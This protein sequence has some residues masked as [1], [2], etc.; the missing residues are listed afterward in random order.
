MGRTKK[1][2][3]FLSFSLIAI[4]IAGIIRSHLQISVN[5][6]GNESLRQFLWS[7]KLK[8]PKE[9]E[10]ITVKKDKPVLRHPHGSKS[11]GRNINI[12]LQSCSDIYMSEMAS[13]IDT[14][15]DHDDINF[16]FQEP[17]PMFD[18]SLVCGRKFPV[19]ALRRMPS[20]RAAMCGLQKKDNS[21]ELEVRLPRVESRRGQRKMGGLS[22]LWGPKNTLG[23][24]SQI[25]KLSNEMREKYGV[26]VTMPC[27]ALP[28]DLEKMKKELPILKQVAYWIFKPG[29][30]VGGSGIRFLSNEE[31][32]KA[33]TF[34]KGTIQG[35]QHNPL[36]VNR[37]K[38]KKNAANVKLKIDFRIY[39]VQTAV[40]PMRLYI[41]KFGYLRTGHPDYNFSMSTSIMENKPVHI[42]NSA[43]LQKG[44]YHDSM[45]KL[46][47]VRVEYYKAME[48]AFSNV[49]TLNK[50]FEI[51]E[52]NG[53]DKEVVWGNILASFAR[54]H[55]GG[56]AW[57]GSGCES[58]QFGSERLCN[59]EFIPFFADAGVDMNGEI[60]I[61]ETHPACN[62]KVCNSSLDSSVGSCVHNIVTEYATRPGTWGSTSM[63]FAKFINPD[64]QLFASEWIENKL[65]KHG[66][67]RIPACIDNQTYFS[68]GCLSSQMKEIL[69][70]MAHE[71]YLACSLGLDDAMFS[72]KTNTTVR[73]VKMQK[74]SA[75]VRAELE[76]MLDKPTLKIYNLYRQFDLWNLAKEISAMTCKGP[77]DV[78]YFGRGE[79]HGCNRTFFESFK[80]QFAKNKESREE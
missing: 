37:S 5:H 68:D 26:G 36:L 71:D 42:T 29:M 46:P 67:D 20:D 48:E 73:G 40:Q 14:C 17:D 22:G 11:S 60:T 1:F 39:G 45:Y 6:G 53:L 24:K 72:L 74:S 52:Q 66:R 65:Q 41:S 79:D 31:I 76:S 21:Y 7:L 63:G 33:K 30:S 43:T 77:N 75:N 78:Y 44:I 8:Y 4:N 35:Y 54:L 51:V 61:F 80:E 13:T 55:A 16:A 58:T 3:S 47:D 23:D 49:A 57:M 38:Y 27:F 12:V 28:E 25:C 34:E 70:E 32:R 62:F 19:F 56:Q 2:L 64:F 59:Q 10:L 69:I 15:F 18:I 9:Y 50:F